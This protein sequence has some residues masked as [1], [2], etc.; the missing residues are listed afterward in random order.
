LLRDGCK[1]FYHMPDESHKAY[2]TLAQNQSA[3]CCGRFRLLVA[4]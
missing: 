1:F 3:S 4:S 2:V